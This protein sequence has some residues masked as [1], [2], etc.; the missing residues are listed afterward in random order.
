MQ[1]RYGIPRNASDRGEDMDNRL[2]QA[3]QFRPPWA[4]GVP[5]PRFGCRTS[6]PNGDL[7]SR[8]A[9]EVVYLIDDNRQVRLA[10]SALL[11]SHQMRVISFES[12]KDFLAHTR[13][14][15]PACLVLDLRL[16]DIGGLE[17][18]QQLTGKSTMPII[19]I[20]GDCDVRSSVHAMKAGALEFL[21]KPLD[22]DVLITAIKGALSRDRRLRQKRAA[23]ADLQSRFSSLTR[24]EREVLP[25]IAGGLLNKQ[26]ADVL[27]IKE[28]TI[29]VHRGQIMRKMAAGTFADLVRMAIKLRIPKHLEQD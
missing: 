24:R 23:M 3:T 26:A 7:G 6:R 21:T 22:E 17:L 2:V 28:V 8:A 4:A 14:D 10:L 25:L 15:S 11:A 29:A 18:Q 16:P 5:S 13:A 9:P 20:S 19:F 27:G 1:A 12:A